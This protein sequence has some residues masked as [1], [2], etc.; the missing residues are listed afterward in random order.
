VVTVADA[1]ELALA[2]ADQSPFAHSVIIES[3]DD[4]G[5]VREDWAREWKRN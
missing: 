1:R 2:E 5:T 3:A 4:S